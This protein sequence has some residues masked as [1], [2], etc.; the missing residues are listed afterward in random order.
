MKNV[1]SVPKIT[2]GISLL[3]LGMLLFLGGKVSPSSQSISFESEPVKVEKLSSDEVDDAKIPKRIIIPRLS[4]DLEVK[5]ADIVNGYW[6]VFP[7]TAA[8]GSGSGIPGEK[9][10]QIIFAHAREGLFLPL[11]SIKVGVK[12]YILSDLGW[13]QYEVREIKE[14]YPNQIEV[15]APTEDETLTLY[16]CSGFSDSKRLI[17]IA[18]RV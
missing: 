6:E 1:T 10:N 16:T 18:K 13:F 11:Q 12:L 7:D 14:V 15:I 4:L 9:G 2:L 17:V 3:F 5:K 8:W